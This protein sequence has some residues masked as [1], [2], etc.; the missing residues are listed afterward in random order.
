ME[1][2]TRNYKGPQVAK[3]ILKKKDKVTGF[4]LT[5]FKTSY[6]T[7]VIRTALCWHTDTHTDK[8][9][10]TESPEINPHV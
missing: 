6:K 4:I 1:K 8:P 9:S 3:K 5:D 2:I 7:T 10:M